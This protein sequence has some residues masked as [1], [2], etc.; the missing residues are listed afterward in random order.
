[1][2]VVKFISLYITVHYF[3]LHIS[4][5]IFIYDVNHVIMPFTHKSVGYKMFFLVCNYVY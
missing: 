5:M 2:F 3:S 1:L 4:I